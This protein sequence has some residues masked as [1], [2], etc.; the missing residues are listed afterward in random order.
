MARFQ[1]FSKAVLLGAITALGIVSAYWVAAYVGN[2]IGFLNWSDVG[3][4]SGLFV[5]GVTSFSGFYGG[6]LAVRYDSR[7]HFLAGLF[8]GFFAALI[9]LLIQLFVGI[10]VVPATLLLPLSMG[11]IGGYVANLQRN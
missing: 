4:E 10:Q 2:A 7:I 6:Y 11:A 3:P 5:R 8:V 9:S 1:I